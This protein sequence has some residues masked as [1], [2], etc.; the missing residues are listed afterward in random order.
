MTWEKSP[1]P[2]NE[3]KRSDQDEEEPVEPDFSSKTVDEFF[4]L[5]N[6]LNERVFETDPYLPERASKFK[7]GIQES[8]IRRSYRRDVENKRKQKASV[9]KFFHFSYYVSIII[10]KKLNYQNNN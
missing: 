8:L 9:T 1:R 10:I 7:I 3:P 2:P 6:Q 4:S 5:A